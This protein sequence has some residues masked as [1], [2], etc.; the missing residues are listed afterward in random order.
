M[1]TYCFQ[2]R[3]SLSCKLQESESVLTIYS[4]LGFLPSVRGRSWMRLIFDLTAVVLT[5]NAIEV[6]YNSFIWVKEKKGKFLQRQ[7]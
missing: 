4:S 2:L 1:E 6:Q 5:V 3:E 7:H